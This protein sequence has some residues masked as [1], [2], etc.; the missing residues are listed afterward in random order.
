V[1]HHVV[2]EVWSE[3]STFSHLVA[4]PWSILNEAGQMLTVSLELKEPKKISFLWVPQLVD[5]PL[6]I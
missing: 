2:G 1:K 6:G 3:V 5:V 4:Y